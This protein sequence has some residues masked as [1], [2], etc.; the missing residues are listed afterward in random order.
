MSQVRQ[1]NEKK[2]VSFTVLASDS[3]DDDN[4]VLVKV[5][6]NYKSPLLIPAHILLLLFGMFKHGLTTMPFGIMGLGAIGLVILQIGYTVHL[7]IMTQNKTCN[8]EKD[9]TE[10]VLYTMGAAFLSLLVF[11][12]VIFVTLILSGAPL[13]AYIPET[14]V[15]SVHLSYIIVMPILV[16][17]NVDFSKIYDLAR[18]PTILKTIFSNPILCSSFCSVIG[19]W[20]GVIPIPLDWDRPWQQWPITLLV[21]AYAGS[22]LGYTIGYARQL[23]KQQ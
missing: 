19:T 1:R 22:V 12:P 23:T 16:C 5:P 10:C 14:F 6:G 17:F 21:G 15:L 8:K 4:N 3:Q 18:S 11:V 20:L 7:Q 9:M 13:Y 2:T